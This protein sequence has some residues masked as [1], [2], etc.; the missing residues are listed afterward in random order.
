MEDSAMAA[1]HST[2]VVVLVVS[3]VDAV[4][5]LSLPQ[6]LLLWFPSFLFAKQ[7]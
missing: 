2:V 7:R 1:S 3:F 4:V 6:G 5:F